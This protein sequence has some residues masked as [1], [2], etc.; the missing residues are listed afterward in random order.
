MDTETRD[1]GMEPI[2]AVAGEPALF[3]RLAASEEHPHLALLCPDCGGADVL[4]EPALDQQG[5]P[6]GLLLVICGSCGRQLGELPRP[7]ADP[8]AGSVRSGSPSEAEA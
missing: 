3:G 4:T 7:A 1:T 8:A 2:Q 6:I 5:E